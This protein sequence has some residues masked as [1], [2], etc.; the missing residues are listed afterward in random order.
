MSSLPLG[1]VAPLL[2]GLVVGCSS[3]AAPPPPDK[4]ALL[5]SQACQACHPNHYQEWSSSM[6]AYS[7]DDPVFIAMNRRGQRETNGQLGDFCVKCHAPVA[8]REGMTHDGLNL[9]DIPRNY[10][11]VTCYFCHSIESVTDA[12][13]NP[14]TLAKDGAMIGGITDPVETPFHL[15]RY[16]KLLDSDYTE[17]SAA[18]GSCHDIVNPKGVAIE[19]TYA[20][21]RGSLFA[22]TQVG[23]GCGHCHL[24]GRD[25]VVAAT[26]ITRTRRVHDHRMPGIDVALTDWPGIEDQKRL[27]LDLLAPSAQ[28]A[29][30]LDDRNNR[31]AA[32]LDNVAVAHSFPS[33]ASSDRRVWAEVV[34][35]A[36]DQVIYQ[37]GVVPDGMTV[38]AIDDPDLWMI[39]DCFFDEAGHDVHMFWQA[40]RYTSNLLPPSPFIGPGVKPMPRGHYRWDL[41][42]PDSMRTLPDVPDRITMKVHIQP[43]GA[44]V[45]KDLIESGDLDPQFAGKI[46]SYEVV[47]ARVNWTKTNNPDAIPPFV[48]RGS[49]LNCV[50]S[51]TPFNTVTNPTISQARC[52]PAAVGNKM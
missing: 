36:K 15:S 43:M 19:R 28:G 14:I 24:P 32:I 30:C 7:S 26:N 1:V 20:E 34:A 48:E 4:M 31:I 37:S 51:A 41:P 22:S 44:E 38:D 33:G 5:D 6:H 2:L 27:I 49:V 45:I 42:R 10:K 12:H 11:G 16:S 23:Q 17:A 8:L 39:R 35:Y 29:L 3:N 52:D 47:G 40:A 9:A 25:G 50:A 21:W 18:C 46:L 13:N